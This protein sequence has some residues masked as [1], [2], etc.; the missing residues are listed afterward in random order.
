MNL[1]F[2]S[3][4][5]EECAAFHCDKHCIKMILELTQLLYS[6]W[7]FGR[8]TF[9]LPE[10]DPLPNDPYRPTHKNHPVSVWV[11]AHPNH[12]H[13]T[14]NLA[15]ALSKEY[16]L[17][18]GKMHACQAHLERLQALGAPEN[19]GVETYQPPLSKRAYAGL[20][21]GIAY[22]DCA[23]NDEFFPSCAVYTDGK[24]NAVETYRKY[25]MCKTWEMKWRA[26]PVPKWYQKGAAGQSSLTGS[27]ILGK[28]PSVH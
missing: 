4:I 22:F 14:L 5:I 20:P 24:L 28:Q 8:D 13:W 18:Y 17:R 1:F 3:D 6:A 23:I 19:V 7:W 10:L 2:L 21:K 9:P 25:Y 15:F 26:N 27:M 12:Y 16:Y 11:R